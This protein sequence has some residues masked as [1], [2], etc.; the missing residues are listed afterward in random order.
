LKL[1]L[2]GAKVKLYRQGYKSP[3]LK[4]AAGQ[5]NPDVIGLSLSMFS[6]LN[7]FMEESEPL[8]PIEIPE[9]KNPIITF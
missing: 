3:Y 2:I 6:Q 8:F 1:S 5:P 7:G 4:L 9:T